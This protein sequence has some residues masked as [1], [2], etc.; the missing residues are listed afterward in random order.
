[1]LL[2]LLIGI[3][4]L[5]V[6]GVLGVPLVGRPG[7]NAP[8]R[9]SAWRRGHPPEP[10]VDSDSHPPFGERLA[11]VPEPVEGPSPERA[12]ADGRAIVL[13]RIGRLT[14]RGALEDALDLAYAAMDEDTEAG[15]G[16]IDTALYEHA[17]TVLRAL[18]DV[19]AEIGLLEGALRRDPGNARLSVRLV[20]ALAQTPARPDDPL[21]PTESG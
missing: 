6:F 18:D 4:S 7:E 14:R 10:A 17:A 19:E 8:R 3:A 20:N 15:A 16:V 12:R 9:M 21:D 11:D 5:V 1:M 13:E 2:L